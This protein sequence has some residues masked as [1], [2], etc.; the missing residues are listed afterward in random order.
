MCT[1]AK[2]RRSRH[3]WQR[4]GQD[5]LGEGAVKVNVHSPSLYYVFTS[6]APFSSTPQPPSYT[7]ASPEKAPLTSTRPALAPRLRTPPALDKYKHIY[8]GRA[9]ALQSHG[10]GTQPREGAVPGSCP[11][12]GESRRTVPCS[13]G[14]DARPGHCRDSAPRPPAAPAGGRKRKRGRAGTA[15]APPGGSGRR[16]GAGAVPP[17]GRGPAAAA[18]EA[19]AAGTSPPAPAWR[20]LP[21]SLPSLLFHSVPPSS[22]GA[23]GSGS[24]VSGGGRDAVL[25]G[26]PTPA[27]APSPAAAAGAG[28]GARLRPRGRRILSPGDA[29]PR[30]SQAA[31]RPR[32][33]AVGAAPRGGAGGRGMRSGGAGACAR[34]Q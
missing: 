29:R 9:R 22:V 2:I 11:E 25:S 8:R 17:P 13:P 4:V 7:Q 14:W 16:G 18:R 12:R 34:R 30:R 28:G 20:S 3:P 31:Q 1:A 15:A 5:S 33:R 26:S 21:P 19:A 24:D 27:A 32:P 10:G 23:A 6:T